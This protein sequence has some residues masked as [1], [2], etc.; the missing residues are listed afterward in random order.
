MRLTVPACKIMLILSLHTFTLYNPT[1]GLGHES[2][3]TYLF[4]NQESRALQRDAHH[5]MWIPCHR[6]GPK[7]KKS[8]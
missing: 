3:K 8:R 5:L 2:G 7:G 1:Y 6:V 4:S